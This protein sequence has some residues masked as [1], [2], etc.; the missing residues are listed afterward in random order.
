MEETDIGHMNHSLEYYQ[1]VSMFFTEHQENSTSLNALPAC[2]G[3]PGSPPAPLC[4]QETFS[5]HGLRP[6]VSLKGKR[7]SSHELDSTLHHLHQL[8]EHV[9][10][11]MQRCQHYG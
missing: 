7:H 2:R 5:C 11:K 9:L 8:R 4:D 3:G 10:G 6:F 1:R